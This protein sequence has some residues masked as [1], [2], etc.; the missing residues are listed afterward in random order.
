MRITLKAA[1]TNAG[2]TQQEAADKIGVTVD[3]LGNWERGK[4]FP[5]A[6]QIRRMEEVYGTPYDRLIFLPLDYD[7][8]VNIQWDKFLS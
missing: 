7:K 3:T 5:N 1:R 8:T 4:S 6:L 2:L